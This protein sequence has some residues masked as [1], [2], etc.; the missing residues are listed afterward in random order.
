MQTLGAA[1]EGGALGIH[2]VR[3]ANGNLALVWTA[4]DAAGPALAYRVFDAAATS[5]SARQSLLGDA[6]T[7]S[8]HTTAL[9]LMARCIWPIS[10]PPSRTAPKAAL[11]M[12][13]HPASTT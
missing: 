4:M 13:P 2:L 7:E 1:P 8:A 5:W 11:R 6:A 3:A 10:A 9:L 12:S